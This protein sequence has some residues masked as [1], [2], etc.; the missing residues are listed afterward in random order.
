M[1]TIIVRPSYLS[2]MQRTRSILVTALFS[3]LIIVGTFIRVPIP[4]VPITLQTFFVMLAALLLPPVQALES[5]L[6]FLLLGAVGVP[7]FSTGGGLGALLGPTG[8]FLLGMAPAAGLGALVAARDTERSSLWRDVLALCIV[9]VCI[10]GIGVPYLKLRLSMTWAKAFAAG[11]TPFVIGD[12]VKLV[13]AFVIARL[14][15]TK[16]R[17]FLSG[18]D[19]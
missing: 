2:V 10:Y 5:V 11:M 4:P 7:V 12:A 16:V 14:F 6:V 19:G 8:G 15:R 3:A 9:Q 1:F 13:A 18:E 17:D